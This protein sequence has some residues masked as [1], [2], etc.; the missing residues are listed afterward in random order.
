MAGMFA[1]MM[2]KRRELRANQKLTRPQLESLKLQKFRQLVAHAQQNSPYYGRLIREHQIDIATCTPQ[3][4]PEL[5]KSILIEHFDEIVTDRRLTR[6]AI[7]EFLSHSTNPNELLFNEY[8][9]V[10]TSGSSG[11][12]GYFVFSEQDWANGITQGPR[13]RRRPARSIG[14]QR[15]RIAYF[16][17]VGGHF[18]GVSMTS[19]MQR[20]IFKY[21]VRLKLL[22]VNDPISKTI[23]QLNEFQPHI[24]IGYT[25]AIRILAEKQLAG[26]LQIAPVAVSTGGEAQSAADRDLFGQAFNCVIANTYGCSEHMMMGYSRPDGETMVLYD[27]DLIYEFYAEHSIVTNLFNYTLPLI[28]YRMSD[29]FRPVANDNSADPYLLVHS[30]VGRSEMV[31]SFTNRESVTDFISAFTIIELFIPGV[32][33]FQMRLLDDTHFEFAICLETGLDEAGRAAAINATETRLQDILK[34]K[35]MDNVQFSIAVVD[36]LA[37]NP[38]TGKFQLI[39]KAG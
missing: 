19:S 31:P 2:R 11:Q 7:S 1:T 34:Q 33:Q 14:W 36:S 37:V 28:R 25:T 18:A 17:A 21:L 5:T 35:H 16:A 20:G 13:E 27:D 15:P 30:L 4:F 9:V 24:L 26:D 39:V 32:S 6:Q 38:K 22:E 23:K 8:H 29:I 12:I 10:H 3:D